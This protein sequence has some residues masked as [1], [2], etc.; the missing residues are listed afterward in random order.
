MLGA[1]RVCPVRHL[2]ASRFSSHLDG[3]VGDSVNVDECFIFHPQD[4][5]L[6]TSSIS[7]SRIRFG[8]RPAGGGWCVSARRRRPALR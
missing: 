7:P 3:A 8:L 4:R 5:P 1:E 2:Q 6:P